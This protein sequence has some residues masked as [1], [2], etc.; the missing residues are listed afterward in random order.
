M[1]TFYSGATEARNVEHSNYKFGLDKTLSILF[2]SAEVSSLGSPLLIGFGL[3]FAEA[4]GLVEMEFLRSWGQG[5]KLEDLGVFGFFFRFSCLFIFVGTLCSR[6]G[7]AGA[8]QGWVS[9]SVWVGRVS[10]RWP[11]QAGCP[12][13]SGATCSLCF[14]YLPKKNLW[15]IDKYTTECHPLLWTICHPENFMGGN[16]LLHMGVEMYCQYIGVCDMGRTPQIWHCAGFRRGKYNSS[17]V[18]MI[19]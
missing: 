14:S 4:E 9:V 10:Q 15:K 1:V 12:Q 7:T 8:P 18:S 3:G 6:S 13:L 11:L 16:L 17:M 19:R 5:V 2:K